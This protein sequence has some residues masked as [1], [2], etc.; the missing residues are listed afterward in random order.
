[1]MMAFWNYG[2]VNSCL[3][4]QTILDSYYSRRPV[5]VQPVGVPTKCQQVIET[6]SALKTIRAGTSPLWASDSPTTF[7]VCSSAYGPGIPSSGCPLGCISH[8]TY[9]QTGR[10][11]SIYLCWLFCTDRLCMPRGENLSF[12][13]ICTSIQRRSRCVNI[14]RAPS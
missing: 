3:G 11:C 2:G 5:S 1:M 12:S 8:L 14:V 13:H 6:G 10:L 7:R 9:S 4:F